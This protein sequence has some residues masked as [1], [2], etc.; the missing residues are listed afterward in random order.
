[1]PTAPALPMAEIRRRYR[2]DGHVWLKGILPRSSVLGFRRHF[3]AALADTGL[4]APGSD[5][6]EGIASG[7][8]AHPERVHAIWM[9]IARSTTYTNF[10]AMP[11]IVH[12]YEEFL[13]GPVQLLRRKII[14]F[15]QPGSGQCTPGH[16]DLIYL[17]A[18]TD[19][20]F[21]SWIPLGD[22]PVEMGG[23]CYLEHSDAVGRRLEAEFSRRNA[24]LPPAER[25][26]AYNRN[27]EAGG[28]VSKDLASL[29]EKYNSRWLI[30]DYEAGDMVVH[31]PY[32]LHASTANV[33]PR[34]R[35]RLSTD[36][37]YLRADGQ[38]D[39]RWGNEWF[40][41]DNL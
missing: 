13:G 41:G 6:E 31:S 22:T 36:I 9:E 8:N 20:V 38:A 1:M 11:E 4:L 21:S 37:R 24:D 17:R 2:R 39:P 32:I 30:A 27:M 28:W 23:L 15:T 18:G 25:I 35:M 3:F 33:D 16:Y 26:S 29:A 40:I 19:Q 5:P 10:C 7:E 34:R 14:R 12:F